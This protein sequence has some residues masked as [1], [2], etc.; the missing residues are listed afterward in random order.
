M[1]SFQ[2]KT[3]DNCDNGIISEQDANDIETL[4]RR[5]YSE[6]RCDCQKCQIDETGYAVMVAIMPRMDRLMVNAS[7]NPIEDA[8]YNAKAYAYYLSLYWGFTDCDERLYTLTYK[9]ARKY[10]TDNVVIDSTLRAT[11]HFKSG[12]KEGIAKGLKQLVQMYF[13]KLQEKTQ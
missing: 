1:A 2:N 9:D 5:I 4:L 8:L 3:V 7:Q 13:G 10:L 12:T 11:K 6:T